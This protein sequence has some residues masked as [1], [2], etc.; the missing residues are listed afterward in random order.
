MI[1]PT[2]KMFNDAV[3]RETER[4][5]NL[6]KEWK[7]VEILDEEELKERIGEYMYETMY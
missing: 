3:D 5:F 4:L 7:C 6:L 1:W 2:E